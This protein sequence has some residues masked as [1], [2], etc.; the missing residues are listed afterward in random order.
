M[1]IYCADIVVSSISYKNRC[2]LNSTSHISLYRS[3]IGQCASNILRRHFERPEPWIVSPHTGVVNFNLKHNGASMPC[4]RYGDRPARIPSSFHCV[5][6]LKIVCISPSHDGWR[7]NVQ[8]G[9]IDRSCSNSSILTILTVLC[10]SFYA[11]TRHLTVNCTNHSSKPIL[12]TETSC[13]IGTLLF[14]FSSMAEYKRWVVYVMYV[15]RLT[16]P[17]PSQPRLLLLPPTLG[18]LPFLKWTCNREANA[19]SRYLCVCVCVCVWQN[20]KT[21]CWIF[22]Q[23]QGPHTNTGTWAFFRYKGVLLLK[24]CLPWKKNAMR[25]SIWDSMLG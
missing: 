12:K 21:T 2:W 5:D 3:L 20:V 6:Y 22:T 8:A 25:S 1:D 9:H 11:C 14:A 18:A 23:Y 7:N 15:L 17:P 10:A 16:P 13:L 4:A 24:Y 19:S